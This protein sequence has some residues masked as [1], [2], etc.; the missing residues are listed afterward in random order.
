ML[1]AAAISWGVVANAAVAAEFVPNDP[2]FP[3]QWSLRNDGSDHYQAGE[4]GTP[5]ADVRA[6]FAW[7]KA[8]AETLEPVTVAVIDAGIIT[9][10]ADLAN[11]YQLNPGEIPGNGVDDDRNGFA[12]DTL[13]WDFASEIPVERGSLHGY[14]DEE[15]HGTSVSSVLAAGHNDGVGMTGI[16]PNARLLIAI[17][18]NPDHP[19]T[20]DA[21][22][23]AVDSGARVVNLSFSSTSPG[24]ETNL[25]PVIAELSERALIVAAAGNQ[26]A[27]ISAAPRW[28]ASCPGALAVAATD[29]SDQLPPYSNWGA[30][31][32]LAAPGTLIEAACRPLDTCAFS[33]TSLAAPQVAGAAAILFGRHP[34]AS[35]AQVRSALLESAA[36]IRPEESGA[37]AGRAIAGGRLDVSAAIDVLDGIIA[38]PIAP[39]LG[40]FLG[41]AP[42]IPAAH[43]PAPPRATGRLKPLAR[44]KP[45][46][47]Q[48]I[49]RRRSSRVV[50]I[51]LLHPGRATRV[52]VRVGS[53]RA[54][55]RRISPRVRV[56]LPPRS[57][58]HRITVRLLPSG[59][60]LSRS[61]V[62]KLHR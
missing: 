13:G 32:P 49:S 2:R 54:V 26:G 61:V 19:R 39:P 17:R 8:P 12:D 6:T 40:S 47:L 55:A 29:S 51:R 57:G 1:V 5:G 9:A 45:T 38:G 46:R 22:R 7:A 30:S 48:I 23:Y 52:S 53:G 35:V 20:A 18:H 44:A 27:D 62:L 60:V 24:T 50:L 31:V 16:A 10:H 58:R 56:I 33:G 36:P 41:H 34:S 14:G 3:F 42:L 37:A 43:I 28:P 21:L 4:A 15:V 59:R 11:S 25:C